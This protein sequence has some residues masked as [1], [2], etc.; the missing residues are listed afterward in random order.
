MRRFDLPYMALSLPADFLKAWLETPPSS[1]A[2]GLAMPQQ[3]HFIPTDFSL[4]SETAGSKDGKAKEAAE[5]LL[6]AMPAQSAKV[7][8]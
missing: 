8:S 2:E 6:T 1:S 7:E 3:N 4:K 5:A